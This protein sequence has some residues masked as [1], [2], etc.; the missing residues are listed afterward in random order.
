M[1]S[2]RKLLLICC[3]F[4]IDILLVVGIVFVC[5]ATLTMSLEKE[6]NSLSSLDFYTDRF[7]TEI[8]S[9][10]NYGKVEEAIK[11]YLDDYA[12]RVKDILSGIDYERLNTFSSNEYLSSM[13]FFDAD[14]LYLTDLKSDFNSNI[15]SLINED[16]DF[17]YNYVYD[18]VD[19]SYF[20]TLY[21]KMIDGN[22]ITIINNNK[23]DLKFKKTLINSYI[24]SIY[25]YISFLKQNSNNY[26]I[27]EGSIE[28]NNDELKI[29]YFKLRDKIKESK[30]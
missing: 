24:D 14:L 11:S 12:L 23:N 6:V 13:L 1:K 19:N 21:N 27:N 17:L 2:R 20:V 25:N 10:G 5:S 9:N 16:N 18:Y 22:I 8:K 28:F 4:I 3:F 29:E 7:N 15:D 30:V 26:I